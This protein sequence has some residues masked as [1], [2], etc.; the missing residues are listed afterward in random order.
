MRIAYLTQ[1]VLPSDLADAVQ[2]MQECH[3]MVEAGHEVLMLAP[4]RTKMPFE[5]RQ[6]FHHFG[7]P[8][9][10]E[11]RFVPWRTIRDRT[12]FH[13]ASLRSHLRGFQ[14]NLV[15]SVVAMEALWAQW[16]GWPTLLEFQEPVEGRIVGTLLGRALRRQRFLRVVTVTDALKLHYHDR[17]E[18]PLEQ[19]VV[20]R[21][22]VSPEFLAAEARSLPEGRPGA[23]S[24]G[25]AG[26]LVPGRGIEIL[27]A[28]AAALP[29]LDFHV[30]GGT[31]GQVA[32]WK[33][34]KATMNLHFYGSI[35]PRDVASWLKACDIL[36]A[37]YGRNV[38]IG[39][40][41]QVTTTSWMSPMKLFEYMGCGKAILTSDLPALREFL[42]H[43]QN[44][45]LC[46]PEDISAWSE[47]LRTLSA[48]EVLR[49]KLG[50]CARQEV[51]ANYTWKKR[52]EI[53]L[54]GLDP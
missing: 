43:N 33:N 46:E 31:E 8:A 52:A 14:P 3:G 45:W 41:D 53:V 11:L 28:C 36:A 30:L 6:V 54:E 9:S 40:G 26:S 15:Y 48:D 16:L 13:G 49:A 34:Q 5:P 38:T 47:A 23:V 37:P 42:R 4:R 27:V 35:P 39:L 24:V 22:G 1:S 50:A 44:A 7:L 25:Y 32:H 51:E 2:A 17:Y 20:A 18:Y 12:Y 19:M 21:N 29:N 10:F